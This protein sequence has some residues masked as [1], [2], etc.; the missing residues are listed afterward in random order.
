MN[1][2]VVAVVAVNFGLALGGLYLAKR[3]W[4]WRQSWATLA[5]AL[6]VWEQDLSQT[7]AMAAKTEVGPSRQSLLRLRQQYVTLQR[8][9]G[10]L[11]YLRWVLKAAMGLGFKGRRPYRRW[12]R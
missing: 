7:L 8:W 2:L 4:H 6:T 3:L 5:D 1:R 12:F 10:Y 11:P 9:L